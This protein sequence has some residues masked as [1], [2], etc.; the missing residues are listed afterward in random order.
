MQPCNLC[1]GA[2]KWWNVGWS[3]I[4]SYGS[5]IILVKNLSSLEKLYKKITNKKFYL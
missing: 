2:L 5:D 4:K 1:M 3:V